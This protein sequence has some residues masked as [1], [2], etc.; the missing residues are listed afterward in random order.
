MA[1]SPFGI[2]AVLLELVRP[3]LPLILI[4]LAS[5]AVCLIAAVR[6]QTLG[7]RKALRLSLLGGALVSILALLLGPWIT[8]ASFADLTGLL[9]WL[10]LIGGAIALGVLAALLL[11]PPFSVLSPKPGT[12]S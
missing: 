3:I 12:Q 2:L 7:H 11:L 8:Q 1:F 10:S 5:I 9:D 6:Q 4:A